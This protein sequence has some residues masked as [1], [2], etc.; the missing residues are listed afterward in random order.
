MFI[1]NHSLNQTAIMPNDH[2]P[3]D[4]D[5]INHI[6]LGTLSCVKI[7]NIFFTPFIEIFCFEI[8]RFFMRYPV[9]FEDGVI[10]LMTTVSVS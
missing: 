4:H 9:K 3:N 10:G 5:R 1:L 8:K 6:V 7:S 2:L